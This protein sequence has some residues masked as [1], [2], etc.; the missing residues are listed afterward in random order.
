MV[1]AYRIRQFEVDRALVEQDASIAEPELENKANVF[2]FGE[3][4]LAAKLSDLGVDIEQLELPYK[5]NYPI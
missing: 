4:E 3:E 2:A 1:Q 5:S